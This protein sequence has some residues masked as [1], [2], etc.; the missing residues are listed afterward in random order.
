MAYITLEG[1][2]EQFLQESSIGL[3]VPSFCGIEDGAVTTL[4][5]LHLQHEVQPSS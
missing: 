3:R 1:M 5:H 4:L 2:T